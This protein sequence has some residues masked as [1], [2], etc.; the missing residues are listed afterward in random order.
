[1]ADCARRLEFATSLFPYIE[2]RPTVGCPSVR[3]TRVDEAHINGGLQWPGGAFRLLPAEN[4]GC[5]FVAGKRKAMKRCVVNRRDAAWIARNADPDSISVMK[6]PWFD[7]RNRLARRPL[8]LGC[9]VP[10]W[11]C[12][13]AARINSIVVRTL[14]SASLHRT[15]RA[16]D[17]DLKT[18]TP[19][20]L[21]ILTMSECGAM[22]WW[23]QEKCE[24]SVKIHSPHGGASF[25]SQSLRHF[26]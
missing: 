21:P 13:A 26:G 18:D 20:R 5:L 10:V 1:V 9:P 8:N 19:C 7:Q 14:R 2:R 3:R 4:A 24:R 22:N 6:A 23:P 11:P 15:V 16:R 17:I 25:Q 12:P